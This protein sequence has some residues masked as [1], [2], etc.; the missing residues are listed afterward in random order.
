MVRLR[1]VR[2]LNALRLRRQLRNARQYRLDKLPE[3]T[4]ARIT[5]VVRAL[6]GPLLAA[7]LSGRSC[8]YYSMSIHELRGADVPLGAAHTL[9]GAVFDTTLRRGP[10]MASEQ[11]AIA[12]LLEDAGECAV[13]DPAVARISVGFDYVTRSKAAFDASPP[14][15]ALL[16]RHRLIQR[17]WF[18][19][20]AVEYRE[21]VLEVG[22]RIT[23]L[24]GGTREPDPDRPSHGAYRDEGTTRFRF[25]GT[26]RF[27]LIISNDPKSL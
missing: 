25:T 18:L 26:P 5:G 19:T 23:V 9:L 24:G 13:I 3:N 15:R 6:D 10:L 20:D 12:F 27:P 8:V 17:N 16:A 4:I 22:A 14:E 7:P 2:W 21:A 1:D 11:D